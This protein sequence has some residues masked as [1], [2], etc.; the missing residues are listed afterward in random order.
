[1]EFL[2]QQITPFI[3]EKDRSTDAVLIGMVLIKLMHFFLPQELPEGTNLAPP[4][5]L[6][7]GGVRL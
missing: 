2:A 4:N 5:N 3:V 7:E 6:R 1:M